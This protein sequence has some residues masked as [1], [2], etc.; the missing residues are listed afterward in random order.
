MS[1]GAWR[2]LGTVA[3]TQA[4]NVTLAGSGANLATLTPA[5]IATLAGSGVDR[6]DATNNALSLS[7]AGWRALGAVALTPADLVTIADI[8]ANLAGL[9]SAEIGTLAGSGIDRLDATDNALSL[10]L[11][12]YSALG[13]VATAS[14]DV[15]A[16]AGTAAGETI[17]GRADADVIKG[18]GGNDTLLGLGG[19]D[20]LN[21]GVGNDTMTG[22]S[23][24][25]IFLFNTTLNAT[26]NVDRVTDFNA[27]DDTI[28][29]ENTG[30][31]TKLGLG[32]L[33]NAAFFRGAAAHDADDRI[34]YDPSNGAL[35]Y[36]SNGS[37]AG[38]AIKFATLAASL[39]LT[40]LDFVV[41]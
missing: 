15:I 35:V 26:G 23:G 20:V 8:G 41:I 21:G 40:H 36:N 22:G 2:G 31:F 27:S 14:T 11:A 9:S 38:G 1:V 5:E 10:T 7:V 13:T 28:E 37:A 17:R 6:I 33:A 24:R 29:L 25:D 30:I 34:I 12:Q 16:I 3:L 4:D 19:D 18:V 32:A 39:A